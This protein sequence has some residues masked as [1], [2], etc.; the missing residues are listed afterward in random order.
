MV[1]VV[2]TVCAIVAS[3][4]FSEA[5][6]FDAPVEPVLLQ[7]HMDG[8]SLNGH[9]SHLGDPIGHLDAASAW[10]LRGQFQPNGLGVPAFGYSADAHWFLVHLKN[11]LAEESPFLIEVGYPTL[12]DV[13][14]YEA[15]TFQKKV[16]GDQVLFSTRDIENRRCLFKFSLPA[17]GEQ[18]YLI[19]VYSTG[20]VHVP[21]K[22]WTQEE[23]L[24][25][26]HT[27]QI[28]FG[29]Y[30]GC[31]VIM[32]LYNLFL[33]LAIRDSNYFYYALF[34]L[35]VAWYQAIFNGLAF[36]YL[37]RE[38][39]ALNNALLPFSL[40]IVGFSVA[41][42]ST[43]FLQ[44]SQ[45]LKW[46]SIP[47]NWLQF[48]C[49]IY[50]V[51]CFL[52]PFRVA[53]QIISITI[54]CG[55]LL[56]TLGG[57]VLWFQGYR[58]ARFYALAWA[59]LLA[60]AAAVVAKE[61][62]F[63]GLHFGTL[64]AVQISS[65][66][67]TLLLSLAL[68]D[69]IHF[70]RQEKEE[71]QRRGS[72]HQ[73]FLQLS[74]E[75]LLDC[76][77]ELSEAR[78]KFKAAQIAC[79]H[80]LTYTR[81]SP[82]TNAYAIFFS[83]ADLSHSEI[84]VLCESGFVK[85]HLVQKNPK[86]FILALPSNFIAVAAG[87]LETHLNDEHQLF[88]PFFNG[89]KISGTL[90]FENFDAVE[91][92]P[93]EKKF[94]DTLSLSLSTVIENISYFSSMEVKA[95]NDAEL[96]AA[97]LVQQSLLP[98]HSQLVT[99]QVDI[100]ATL[101]SAQETGGDWF[102]YI[103][104]KSGRIVTLFVGDVTGHGISSALMTGVASGAMSGGEFIAE[105]Y[106]SQKSIEDQLLA[107]AACVNHALFKNARRS[108]RFMTMAMLALDS[109]T[110]ELA[111][112]NAA[113]VHPIIVKKNGRAT[114]FLNSG[115]RLGFFENPLFKVKKLQLEKGD[116]VLIFTDGLT[117]NEEFKRQVF[118]TRALPQIFSQFITAHQALQ[119]ILL[120]AE[121]YW[122]VHP[123]ADDVTLAV[124]QWKGPLASSEDA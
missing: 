19:R 34:I 95:K 113:H 110:G 104:D 109:Q 14:I 119:K 5:F 37:W 118:C 73:A 72:Q 96:T 106:L 30:Y 101:K 36:E 23:F 44:L 29:F 54:I 114:T 51:L 47:M 61:F 100:A 99:P 77:K 43:G 42:F 103:I 31:M 112:I 65:A 115:P 39:P 7:P 26:D 9:L 48:F 57:N 90:F 102:N 86:E 122:N 124:L 74:L 32:A 53:I 93:E 24:Q 21:L 92:L 121:S 38:Q 117:E 120:S 76:T 85:D 64:Y 28:V 89:H 59:P 45:R 52:L 69:K 75:R 56:L 40:A 67:N 79:K 6:G 55:A 111:Y 46:L 68:A 107:A 63:I 70:L 35:A 108:Q 94:A 91:L 20:S 12:D 41:R 97:K 71:A 25:Q 60:S 33:F 22:I 58:P 11:P 2:V 16:C 123:P 49:V 3:F 83:E 116:Y 80:L 50:M 87:T 84:I 81:T 66:L 98:E 8:V 105:T 17:Y 18:S 4:F 1:R 10:R 13:R 82:Q 78:D 27:E 62:N 88:V 15:G